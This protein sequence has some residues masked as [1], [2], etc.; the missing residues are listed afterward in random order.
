MNLGN[1]D[2]MTNSLTNRYGSE[3]R[4][5]SNTN[6]PLVETFT[7]NV[8]RRGKGICVFC[9]AEH[10]SDECDQ[11][12]ELSDH[13]KKFL[14]QG[15]CF[16]CLKTGHTVRDCTSSQRN[17]CYYCGKQRYHNRAICPVKFGSDPVSN[18]QKNENIVTSSEN[19]KKIGEFSYTILLLQMFN[20]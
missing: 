7:T 8:Q 12:K 1:I 9:K 11:C 20:P 16:L 15:R 4:Q 3:N 2:E 19:N 5:G 13:K 10:F 14:S 18:Q 17:G 6:L